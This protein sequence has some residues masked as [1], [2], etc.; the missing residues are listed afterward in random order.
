MV[1]SMDSCMNMQIIFISIDRRRKKRVVNV[2]IKNQDGC[3]N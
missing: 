1:V 2:I 3:G